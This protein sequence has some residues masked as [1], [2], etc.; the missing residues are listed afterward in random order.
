MTSW[1][2]IAQWL[3]AVVGTVAVFG[4]LVVGVLAWFLNHPVD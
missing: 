3:A 1:I 4:G 2:D